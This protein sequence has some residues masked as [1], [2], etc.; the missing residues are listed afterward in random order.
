MVIIL[1]HIP[2]IG[3]FVTIEDSESIRLVFIHRA[4]LTYLKFQILRNKGLLDY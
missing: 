2:R 1:I 4:K 3:I